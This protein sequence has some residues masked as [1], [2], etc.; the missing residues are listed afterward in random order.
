M[1]D[2]LIRN[3][4][5]VDGSGNARFRADVAIQDDRIV[6]VDILNAAQ[7]QTVIDASGC[8]VTPGFVDMHSHTDFTLPINPTADSYIYQGITTAVV[9][10]CGAS[11]APLLQESGEQVAAAISSDDVPLPW[12]QWAS[13]GEFYAYLM[14]IGISINVVPMV[15]QGMIRMG[16][17]SALAR[18]PRMRRKWLRMQAEVV[19]AMDE[20]ARRQHGFD[21]PAR[22][23]CLHRRAH[24]FQQTG[25][26]AWR[27]LLQPHSW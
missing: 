26:G 23:I 17:S 27:I 22:I 21:L 15:G 12:D 13:F 1:L 18:N 9:G 10:Q 8:V 19:K 24:R 20:G 11:L 16:V 7:A 14:R 5:I 25:G 2:I 3:G 6:D 4:T